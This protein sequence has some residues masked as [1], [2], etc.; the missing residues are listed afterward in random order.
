MTGTAYGVLILEYYRSNSLVSSVESAHFTSSSPSNSWVK[1]AVTNRAPWT[2]AITGRVLC[3]IMGSTVGYGGAMFF[4]G[5]SVTGSYVGVTNAQAGTIWNPGFEYTAPGTLMSFLD[6]WTPLG[7]AGLVSD[8]IK[9]S[10]NNSLRI[11]GPETMVAQTWAA[12]PGYKYASSAFA[13]TPSG[14]RLAGVSNLHGVVLLQFFDATGTNMLISYESPWFT[15]ST[16]ANVWSNLEVIGVAPNNS[17]Y[18]RTVLGLLGTNTGFGGSLYFDDATQRVVATGGSLSGML[19]NPGFD[20]GP[21]GNAAILQA[22]NDLPYWQWIGGADAGFVSREYKKDYEQ[23]FSITYP[24]NSV[25]QNWSA[26][27]GSSYKAEGYLFTPAASKFNT[28]GKSSGR[29]EISFYVDG[30]TNAYTAATVVSAPFGASQPSNTWVYF[31]VTGFAPS[32]ASIVTGRVT[33]TIACAGDPATDG[34]LAGVIHFDQLTLNEVVLTSDLAIAV[35]DLPDPVRVGTNLTYSIAVT[36]IGPNAAGNVVV[37]DVLPTNVN[38]ISCA[39][40]QGSYVQFEDTVTCDMGTIGAGSTAAVTIVVAPTLEGVVTNDVSVSTSSVDPGDNRA[41]CVTTILAQNR[42]PE[43]VFDPPGPY[44]LIVGSSTSVL[45]YA[46]DPEH[47]PALTITNTVKPAGATYVNSNFSWTAG[48]SFA[49]TTNAVVFVADDHAGDSYSV[50]TSSTF[51]VVP[52]DSNGNG[53]NDGWEWNQFTNLTTSSS[54]D[55]DSDGMNNYAEYVAGTQPTNANSKF[56]I[57]TCAGTSGTSNRIV[58]V[59]TETNR[60]YT[61]Y[62]A[63]GKFSNSIPWTSFLNSSTGIWIETRGSTNYTFTDNEGTNTSGAAP[64]AGSRLYKVKA[65]VP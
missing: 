58:T 26:T 55:N 36:N 19:H 9:R 64:A 60:K 27:P 49:G 17:S 42:S 51:I 10:G 23:S 33:C 1:F 61:I 15:T 2:G 53:I 63:D 50:V 37:T 39:L 56:W 46:Q 34:A 7:T 8:A 41:S 30:D 5:L 25:A 24:L 13:Y 31:A 29:L 18:G 52:F 20:D 57:V 44:T 16:P 35:S 14:D 54:G 59:S 47:D 65:E 48:A 4:D 3:A 11:Y 62:F 12:T 45:V 38:F 22:T 32:A 28:D 6:S 21:S 43:I 40:S